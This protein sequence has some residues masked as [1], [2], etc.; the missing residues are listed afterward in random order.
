M[1]RGL[2]ITTNY[3]FLRPRITRIFFGWMGVNRY[4]PLVH[5]AKAVIVNP[6]LMTLMQTEGL[7]INEIGY[8]WNKANSFVFLQIE[9]IKDIVP[10]AKHYNL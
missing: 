1:I 2:L 4:S 6:Q 3:F 7:E 10:S 9:P 5:Q 8:L